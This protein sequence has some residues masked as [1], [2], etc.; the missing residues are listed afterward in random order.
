MARALPPPLVP[1][2]VTAGPGSPEVCSICLAPAVGDNV[3]SLSCAQDGG[4]CAVFHEACIY[5][6]SNSE[7]ERIL[8]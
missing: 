5:A 6:F 8:F 7:L 2:A 3:V 4:C 1:D